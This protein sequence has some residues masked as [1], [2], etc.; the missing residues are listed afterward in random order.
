[1]AFENV[2]LQS[3]PGGGFTPTTALP[4][5]AARNFT[6]NIEVDRELWR[7][8]AL[9]LSYLNSQTQDL[10]IV[11]PLTGLPGG[12]SALGLANTGKSRYYEFESTL[13][14]QF[15]ERREFSVSYVHSSAHGDLNTLSKS[16][17]PSSS[18]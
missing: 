13:H 6:W 15:G 12:V 7:R 1:M 14:Y 2:Y 8:A 4:D 11:L 18:R 3:L 9:R 16:S 17:C 5:N 10:A